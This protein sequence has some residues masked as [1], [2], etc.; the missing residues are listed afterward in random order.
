M[1]GRLRWAAR[2]AR[3]AE[4]LTLAARLRLLWHDFVVHGLFNKGGERCQDCGRDTGGWHIDDDEWIAVMGY[5][6]GLLCRPCFNRRETHIERT[7]HE[8]AT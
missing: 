1:L 8:Q 3:H 2:T 5:P 6:S 7:H 4:P